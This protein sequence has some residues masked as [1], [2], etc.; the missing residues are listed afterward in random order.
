MLK[1]GARWCSLL[2]LA[3]NEWTP[4]PGTIEAM[5]AFVP[6]VV[7]QHIERGKVRASKPRPVSLATEAVILFADVSGFTAL[8]EAY[9]SQ[10]ASGFEEVS[11]HLNAYF[12]RLIDTCTLHVRSLARSC[13]YVR[14]SR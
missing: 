7:Q 13:K 3:T 2:P 5:Q 12:T 11:R 6:L 10:G 14:G 8:N 9:A 4:D 1:L